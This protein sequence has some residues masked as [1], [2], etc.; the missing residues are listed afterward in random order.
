[1]MDYTNHFGKTRKGSKHIRSFS[2]SQENSRYLDGVNKGQRSRVVNRAL[3]YLRMLPKE[4]DLLSNIEGLQNVI[5]KLQQEL[6]EVAST[7]EIANNETE[8]TS[9]GGVWGIILRVFGR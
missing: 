1:M 6:D 9:P 4:K 8:H 7:S 2:L 3:D 5:R